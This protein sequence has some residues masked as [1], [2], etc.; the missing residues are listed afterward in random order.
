M[1][2]GQDFMGMQFDSAGIESI[3]E[4]QYYRLMYYFEPY[5]FFFPLVQ[6]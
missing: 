2:F 5:F 6:Q 3:Q 4:V 1:I